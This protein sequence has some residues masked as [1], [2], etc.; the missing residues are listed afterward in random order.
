MAYVVQ[1][2]RHIRIACVAARG[3]TRTRNSSYHADAFQG[4]QKAVKSGKTHACTHTLVHAH[5]HITQTRPYTPTITPTHKHTH[6][7]ARAHTHMGTRNRTRMHAR[8]HKATHTHT[9]ARAHS[10]TNTH[11]HTHHDCLCFYRHLRRARSITAR[12]SASAGRRSR[13]EDRPFFHADLCE[14][15]ART[16]VPPLGFRRAGSSLAYARPSVTLAD[17]GADPRRSRLK[18]GSACIE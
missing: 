7:R 2:H 17:K 4:N 18:I 10:H 6:P 11:T 8:R 12:A 15:S 9:R 14:R 5:T 1:A 16:A 13:R 3:R